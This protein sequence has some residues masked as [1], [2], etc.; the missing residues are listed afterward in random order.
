VFL[1]APLFRRLALRFNIL[2]VPNHRKIHKESTPLLGGLAVY[3]GVDR[4]NNNTGNWC[5]R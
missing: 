3:A 1:S 5:N 4:F 2:D